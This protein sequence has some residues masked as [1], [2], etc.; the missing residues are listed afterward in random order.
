MHSTR[1]KKI[2]L[3]MRVVTKTQFCLNA[4]IIYWRKYIQ[5]Y[6]CSSL[7]NSANN[8]ITSYPLP[9]F[10]LNCFLRC[11]ETHGMA[12]FFLTQPWK[13]ISLYFLGTPTAGN[14]RE[15][16]FH[17]A[18]KSG[19]GRTWYVIRL[20]VFTKIFPNPYQKMYV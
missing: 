3:A 5:H 17:F 4:Q 8:G 12:F 14:L 11:S 16:H 20:Q 1:R 6:H 2:P 10:C 13:T 7:L 9:N 19:A 15:G 18:K